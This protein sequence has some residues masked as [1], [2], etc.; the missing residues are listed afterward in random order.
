MGSSPYSE[1]LIRHARTG[2]DEPG[3]PEKPSG[4]LPGAVVRHWE[5]VNRLCG[6]R[7]SVWMQ[8]DAAEKTILKIEHEAEGC[9]LCKASASILRDT[10]AGRSI[11]EAGQIHEMAMQLC[12]GNLPMPEIPS[13]MKDIAALAEVRLF[14]TRIRCM[15]LAW[16]GLPEAL[17]VSKS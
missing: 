6:D 5:S 14:P 12:D 15:K 9:M 16:E 3:S 2:A 17:R 1:I 11:R 10:L 4:K 7:V 13:D 8:L